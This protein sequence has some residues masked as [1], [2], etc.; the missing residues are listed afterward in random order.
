MA[1]SPLSP[2][3][4]LP[5]MAP[6]PPEQSGSAR[7]ARRQS[8]RNRVLVYAVLIAALGPF[9]LPIY[10][11]IVGALTPAGSLL[12][13]PVN[14]LP[15]GL[16]LQN[17]HSLTSYGEVNLPRYALNTMY[18]CGFSVIAGVASSSLVAYGFARIDFPG[19]DALFAVLIATII[20]PPW[21]TLIPQYVLFKWLGWVGTFKPLTF[22]Y[23]FGDAFTI[24]LFRQFM[25]GIPRELSEAAKVDGASEFT[26]YW[27]IILPLMRPTLA[28]GA[29]FIFINT[30]NDFFGPLIYLTDPNHYTLSLAA[31]QFVQ[32]H[33]A[34]D[35]GAIIAYTVVVVA[36]LVIVFFYAQRTLIG[37]IKL[38][39]LRG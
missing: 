26:I 17:F 6:P 22:P 9:L 7:R 38:T 28:V 16:T 23:L 39:G 27:R 2:H 18:I 13:T 20:L 15:H 12:Q 10:W 19:R 5:A 8:L 25:L 29:L 3:F 37:G 31:F 36:P 1:T 35:I 14:W 32:V 24:F 30:Y 34:P 33:G 11:L 21:A 4:E